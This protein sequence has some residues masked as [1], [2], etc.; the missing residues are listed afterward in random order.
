MS[1]LGI[2]DKE[3]KRFCKTKQSDSKNTRKKEN[4]RLKLKS[5]FSSVGLY[6]DPFFVMQTI[7]SE[8]LKHFS[9]ARLL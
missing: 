5:F 1:L 6:N 9:M 7:R 4:E 8:V 2:L 3:P